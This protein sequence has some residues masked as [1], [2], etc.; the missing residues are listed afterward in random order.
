MPTKK[1][2]EEFIQDA[3]KVHGDKYDYSKVEYKTS[4]SPVLL[5]CSE[6]GEFWQTPKSHLRGRGCQKCGKKQQMKL[7]MLSI[8][9]EKKVTD[10]HNGLY[11]YQ[12]DYRGC[13]EPIDILCLKCNNIFSQKPYKHLQG[14]GCPKCGVFKRGGNPTQRYTTETWTKIANKIH[15]NTFD[16]SKVNYV[17]NKTPITIICK[18][19]GKFSQTPS[20][21]LNAI[22][23]CPTCGVTKTTYK[24]IKDA[25]KKHGL[26]YDYSKSIYQ[27]AMKKLIITC[28]EHGDF[29]QTP[30]GHLSGRGCATCGVDKLRKIF[31]LNN[32]EF[33]KKSKIVHGNKWDY[34]EVEYKNYLQKVTIMCRQHG[35]FLQTPGN[36][37]S[38]NGCPM[39]SHSYSPTSDEWITRAIKMKGIGL[40]DFSKTKY[41][42]ANTKINVQCVKHGLFST[43][44]RYFL[45]SIRCCPKSGTCPSCYMWKTDGKLCTYTCNDVA[46]QKYKQKSKEWNIVKY[47]KEKLPD[48]DFIH[49]K[50]VGSHCTKDE[51]EN[52]NGHLFPDIRFDCGFYH[53][54]V[55]VDEHKHRGADYKCDEQRMYNIIAKLGLPCIFIRYN[56]DSK[57]SNKEILLKKVQEYLEL[58][59]EDD[60]RWD[61]FGFKVE[62]LFY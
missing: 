44:P 49:N 18:V 22:Y 32:K 15:K 12:Q 28:K 11:K 7:R 4:I 51:K 17:N 53:L 41:V 20:R 8:D 1:T 19:H 43:V 52:S 21:H 16:Y 56:P 40:Y 37:L 6:H 36:H 54:I 57:E 5:I 23:G 38:G 34:S 3:I 24:F 42:N 2:T 62:Y 60:D 9:F 59:I 33:I 13:Y 55:E 46:I 48:Y 29:K 45:G 27:N 61:D 31:S 26:L 58:D 30:N 10:I 25:I 47:L 14:Q 35:K 39:C 50:S